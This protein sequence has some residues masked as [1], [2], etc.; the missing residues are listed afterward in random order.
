[1]NKDLGEIPEF[2][3]EQAEAMLDTEDR[4]EH[5]PPLLILD[6]PCSP[7]QARKAIGLTQRAMAK[8]LDISPVWWNRIEKGRAVPSS[9]L[10][11]A[12][13]FMM[14]TRTDQDKKAIQT[15][16]CHAVA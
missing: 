2:P 16:L 14:L 9:S 3:D 1:M 13:M 7:K 8:A 5:Q 6:P 11:M 12:V 15:M 10:R 4:T